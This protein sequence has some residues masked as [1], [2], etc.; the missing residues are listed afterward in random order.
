VC[1]RDNEAP[2]CTLDDEPA[3]VTNSDDA[4]CQLLDHHGLLLRP[5]EAKASP[6]P[7]VSVSALLRIP[8]ATAFRIVIIRSMVIPLRRSSGMRRL[9]SANA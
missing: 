7:Q 9:S 8:F 3:A 6:I 2:A 4:R 1:G 5:H